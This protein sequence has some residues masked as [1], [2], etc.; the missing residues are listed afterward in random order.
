[1]MF[2]WSLPCF[3]FCGKRKN[4]SPFPRS[5][6]QI[7]SSSATSVWSILKNCCNY[8]LKLSPIFVMW[9]CFKMAIISSSLT[10]YYIQNSQ[11]WVK[12]PLLPFKSV[13]SIFN[14]EVLFSYAF[15]TGV[16][17]QWQV[18]TI[19]FVVLPA[20]L[21]SSSGSGAGTGGKRGGSDYDYLCKCL[22][23]CLC[24]CLC[25]YLCP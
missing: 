17:V 6:V 19:A 18:A 10:L 9:T 12:M 20:I 11:F 7:S 2:F 4:N 21:F 8:A 24:M 14:S 25:V 23:E 15:W 22:C 16:V 13:F 3:Q 5:N 1:M